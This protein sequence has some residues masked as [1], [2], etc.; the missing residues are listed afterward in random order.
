[1]TPGCNECQWVSMGVNG[2][3]SRRKARAVFFCVVGCASGDG[4]QLPMPPR[5]P[6]TVLGGCVGG[7][8]TGDGS[9]WFS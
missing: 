3:G 9:W 4:S 1:M 7:W 2:D 6:G 8:A 5:P